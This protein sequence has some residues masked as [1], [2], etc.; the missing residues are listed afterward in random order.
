MQTMLLWQLGDA[1]LADKTC[2][3]WPNGLAVVVVASDLCVTGLKPSCVEAEQGCCPVGLRGPVLHQ[4]CMGV[5][6]APL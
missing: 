4:W 3:M 2:T 6:A 5:H 1:Q